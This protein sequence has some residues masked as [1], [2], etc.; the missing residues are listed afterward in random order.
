MAGN[1]IATPEWL[2]VGENE[3]IPY[4][5][6]GFSSIPQFDE[7]LLIPKYCGDRCC[8]DGGSLY[9]VGVD[10][11]GFVSRCWGLST[12]YCSA[13]IPNISTPYETW[14]ALRPGDCFN[15]PGVHVILCAEE[16][17]SGVVL[18]VES[19]GI[20]WRV[21]YRVRTYSSLTNYTPRFYN[22]V[23]SAPFIVKVIPCCLPVRERP[24]PTASVIDLIRINSRF[25]AFDRTGNGW[26]RIHLPSGTGND[27]GFVKGHNE[28]YLIGDQ[29]RVWI[30]VKS[31]KGT[32]YVKRG[33]GAHYPTITSITT[34]Q[35]FAVI[36]SIGDWYEIWLPGSI[37]ED[38][39]GWCLRGPNAEY[40]EIWPGGPMGEYKGEVVDF[41][42]PDTLVSGERDDCYI[43]YRN[44]SD[45]AWDSSTKLGTAS[46]RDRESAFYDSSW[47]ST[48]RVTRAEF[49][50]LPGQVVNF[51]FKLKA[52]E[53]TDPT[54]YNEYFCPV[55]DGYTWFPDSVC[56]TIT[57]LP[58][59]GV[60]EREVVSRQA[61]DISV[62]PNPFTTKTVISYSIGSC[63]QSSVIGENHKL[64]TD[65]GSPITISIYDLSGRLIR[66]LHVGR[67]TPQT[68]S[69]KHEA[70][71]VIWDG[72]DNYGRHLPSGVYFLKTEGF[73]KT[74]SLVKIRKEE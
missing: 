37:D 4:K 9:A 52:P 36:D 57:V 25:V 27:F 48:T 40:L 47:I 32:M 43:R 12:K 59:F 62:Y 65:Y 1:G 49:P 71:S 26:Y 41:Y 67:S 61:M 60:A 14:D 34:G 6:G 68:S 10:C 39:V 63:G 20:D 16:S 45:V 54:V 42:F 44:S 11:S 58:F 5:W 69:I 30:E 35:R 50:A 29:N 3:A 31:F 24:E 51:S 70:L 72:K 55:E 64:I 73:S 17:P 18:C 19:S 15:W 22:G 66:K 8:D 56:F 46:P 74:I 23:G 28:N 13:T 53:V 7:G 38:S 21:S 2:I 33:P